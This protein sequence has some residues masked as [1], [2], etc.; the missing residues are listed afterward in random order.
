MVLGG[1][2]QV[3]EPGRLHGEARE[4]E[5]RRIVHREVYRQ[6]PPKVEY[7]LTALGESLNV[8]LAPLDAWGAD[9]MDEI[10]ATRSC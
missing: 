8:A 3:H 6:V 7:S 5:S 9:H 4:L 1:L 10:T 2:D